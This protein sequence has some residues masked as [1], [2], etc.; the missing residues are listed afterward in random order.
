MDAKMGTMRVRRDVVAFLVAALVAGLVPLAGTAREQATVAT[1]DFPGWPSQHE[2]R[3]LTELPLTE[4]EASF[5]KGFPG[6]VGRFS[7]G[8]REIIIRWVSAPTRLLHG[9]ADC[10]RGSGYS[11][12]PVPV[13]RDAAGTPMGCFRASRSGAENLI[14][15]EVIRDGRGES[16]PDVSAWYWNAL[17]GSGG[18]PWWS[19]VVAEKG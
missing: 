16:W 10:F 14:V 8:R 11:V 13:R 9:S 1:K 18:G 3:A 2:G 17:F 19:F 12:A 6:Q 7:D 15:C 4:R 5:V